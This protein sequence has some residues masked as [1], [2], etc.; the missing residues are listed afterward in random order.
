MFNTV[1]PTPTPPRN[2]YYIMLIIFNYHPRVVIKSIIRFTATREYENSVSE[3]RK[4]TFI[5]VAKLIIRRS[6]Y[7]LG[8]IL[9]TIN[10]T[11]SHNNWT[12]CLAKLVFMRWK[13]KKKL[14]LSLINVQ[15]AV[16]TTSCMIASNVEQT[17]C[18]ILISIKAWRGKQLG[19]GYNCK[20]LLKHSHW[21]IGFLFSIIKLLIDFTLWNRE[22]GC[23]I[24]FN[25]QTF[26]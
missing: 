11:E 14:S 26:L 22:N 17:Y 15:F 16:Y 10:C 3:G 6:R 23:S 21:P 24:V 4:F 19:V 18:H 8:I 25:F 7:H 9:E 1:P 5:T 13:K 2:V 12:V 20:Y